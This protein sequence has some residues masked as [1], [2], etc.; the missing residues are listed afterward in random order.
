[1]IILVLIAFVLIVAISGLLAY[2]STRP[3]S[4]EV[5]RSTLINAPPETI[6]PLINSPARMNIWNPF[7][8]ADPAIKLTYS[9]P[10]AGVGAANAWDGTSKVGK[11]DI[12]ITESVAPSRIALR[13][14]MIKPMKAQNYV[15]YTLVPRGA[16]TE[17]TWMMQG[18]QPFM[19]KLMSVV[20]NCDRMVGGLFEKGLADLKALAEK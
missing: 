1:M 9:G 16:A 4:F 3:D 13:L 14:N 11:G 8:K 10:E 19:A 5:S 17:V 20:I 7:V 2:A 12:E 18:K 15:E 6:F